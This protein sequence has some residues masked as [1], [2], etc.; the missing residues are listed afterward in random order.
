MNFGAL[1]I[2]AVRQANNSGIRIT[3]L[4]TMEVIESNPENM[5]NPDCLGDFVKLFGGPSPTVFRPNALIDAI[6]I[7]MQLTQWKF[8][9]ITD[10]EDM[11]T[12][13][14]I[15]GGCMQFSRQQWAFAYRGEL[16]RVSLWSNDLQVPRSYVPDPDALSD[17]VLQ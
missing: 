2:D 1:F 9:K 16:R 5:P 7:G 12:T 14:D 13:I 11:A 10:W 4:I 3:P 6:I 17:E 15:L 8:R